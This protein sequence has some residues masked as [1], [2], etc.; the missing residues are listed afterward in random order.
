MQSVY[1]AAPADWADS[2]VKFQVFL[3]VVFFFLSQCDNT[4]SWPTP[5]YLKVVKLLI[6][7]DSS[8]GFSSFPTRDI[9][10]FITYTQNTT[11]R[12]EEKEWTNKHVS[13]SSFIIWPSLSS[14]GP[15]FPPPLP[16]SREISSSVLCVDFAPKQ[17]EILWPAHTLTP[18]T[19]NSH[20]V[21]YSS[22]SYPWHLFTINYKTYIKKENIQYRHNCHH[23]MLLH[24][25]NGALC[26]FSTKTQAI[27]VA[28]QN[29]DKN[30]MCWDGGLPH[31][32][33]SLSRRAFDHSQPI[34]REG[35]LTCLLHFSLRVK[36]IMVSVVSQMLRQDLKTI[37]GLNISDLHHLAATFYL[38]ELLNTSISPTP[39]KIL[40]FGGTPQLTP[41]S[42]NLGGLLNTSIFRPTPNNNPYPE[43]LEDFPITSIFH[44][45]PNNTPYPEG[46]LQLR[47]SSISAV[48]YVLHQENPLG[49]SQH[50]WP[51][52]P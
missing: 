26:A 42:R 25:S 40:N 9:I 35:I 12:V 32:P 28:L 45:T 3:S 19:T 5:D 8:S 6:V 4:P 33:K 14:L 17:T 39:P 10:H 36:C 7:S 24:H 50:M 15:S 29:Y 16:V 34:G 2:F 38:R 18:N 51:L 22:P 20:I 49:G 13:P 1:S 23:A 37:R 27:E 47:A 44:T 52:A 21:S 30:A 11:E 48:V 31:S 46:S 43:T 41:I